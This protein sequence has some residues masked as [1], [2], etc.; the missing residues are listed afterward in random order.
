MFAEHLAALA[1]VAAAEA[2]KREEVRVFLKELDDSVRPRGDGLRKENWNT[3]PERIK[4]E[5]WHDTRP[6]A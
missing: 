3:N 4:K 6:L 1:A 5:N 2:Q